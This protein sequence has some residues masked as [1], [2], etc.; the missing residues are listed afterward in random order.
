MWVRFR[1][2]LLAE[3]CSSC[4]CVN[5][6]LQPLGLAAGVWR[7]GGGGTAVVRRTGGSTAHGTGRRR[8]CTERVECVGVGWSAVGRRRIRLAGALQL[9]PG[10]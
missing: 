10:A 3:N 8:S 4:T 9:E 1:M 7:G 5:K 2:L 6:V